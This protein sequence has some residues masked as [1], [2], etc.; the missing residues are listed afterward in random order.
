[1]RC[2]APGY[3]K[4]DRHTPSCRDPRR[5]RGG[6]IAADGG[7]RGRHARTPQ[8]APPRAR[9]SEDRRAPGPHRQRPPA[10]AREGFLSCWPHGRREILVEI[11]YY[12][13]S[14]ANQV[15]S[16]PDR[17]FTDRAALASLCRRRQIRR[18]WL[19]GSL[20]KGNARSDSDVSICWSNSR[21]KRSQASSTLQR[22][23]TSC[24]RCL[25]DGGWI[26]ALPRI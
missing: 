10:T 8:G 23:S 1:M 19:F 26:C 17:L 15:T 24:R 4:D 5:R 7:G 16:M 18:L 2:A 12:G 20:L 13:S 14:S 25:R 21:V 11:A 6:V 3:P 22:S 9:R